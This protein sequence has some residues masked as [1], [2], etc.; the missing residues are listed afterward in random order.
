MRLN[1]LQILCIQQIH[2]AKAAQQLEQRV[3]GGAMPQPQNM[4]SFK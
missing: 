2:C 3:L 4:C 1:K